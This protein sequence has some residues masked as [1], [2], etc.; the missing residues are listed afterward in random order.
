V[1]FAR[2][3]WLEAA[4]VRAFKWFK[5]SPEIIRPAVMM[6]VRFP[7]SLRN[8]EDVLHERGIARSHETLRFW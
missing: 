6:Y 3:T 7:L 1:G 5:T 2:T 4:Q 8:V